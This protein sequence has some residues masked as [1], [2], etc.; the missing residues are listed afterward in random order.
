MWISVIILL[1][2]GGMSWYTLHAGSEAVISP[3]VQLFEKPLEKYTIERLSQR[4]PQGSY[5]V[6]GEI[7]AT[8]SAYRVQA[9]HF[10]SDGKQVT[11]LAHIPAEASQIAQK[12]VIVQVRGY[13]EPD[14]YTPGVGT[15]RSAEVFASN[16]FISLAPDFLGYGDSDDPSEDVFEE[17][18]QTYTVM[19]DLLASIATLSIA[20]SNR[21]G[22]WAHSNG[23]QIAL[24]VLEATGKSYPTTLW[25][26]VTKPFPYSILYY[27]DEAEDHG[28]ALRKKLADFEE[29]YDVEAYAMTNFLDRIM[30]PLQL[31]QGTADVAVPVKWNEEFVT[32]LQDKNRDIEYFV[33]PG[34]D[35]N[36]S[37]S[38]NTVMNRDISFFRR[39]FAN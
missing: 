27:T 16:G 8:E 34:A 32:V 9:F 17:R 4:V 15:K 19:L 26:P 6:L 31:H 35:H 3:V 20:D 37:P 28:K 13:V 39:M 30:A 7:M 22:I 33:Y 23:G 10:T 21:V 24:T 36:L 11:G 1:I 12:P 38:W 5:I 25:A 29:L 14:Q 18:F 2:A